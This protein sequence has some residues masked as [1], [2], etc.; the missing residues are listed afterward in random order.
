MKIKVV[1]QIV[2][3]RT[4]FSEIKLFNLDRSPEGT[5]IHVTCASDHNRP[6]STSAP[7]VRPYVPSQRGSAYH[8]T[9]LAHWPHLCRPHYVPLSPSQIWSIH[10]MAPNVFCHCSAYSCR[11]PRTSKNHVISRIFEDFLYVGEQGSTLRNRKIRR[12]R[13]AEHSERENRTCVR[14]VCVSNGANELVP[15]SISVL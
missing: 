12:A 6:H 11:F 15:F 8:S 7:R 10:T 13:F 1:G 3:L 2:S 5:A 4:L 14:C 9:F